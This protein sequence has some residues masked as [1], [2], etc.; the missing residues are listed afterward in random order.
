MIK[1]IDEII[2]LN[3]PKNKKR[4]L[5]WEEIKKIQILLP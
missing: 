5:L 1:K 2:K 4:K 3:I